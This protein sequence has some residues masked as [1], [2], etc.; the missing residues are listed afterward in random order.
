MRDIFTGSPLQ[1]NS[2]YQEFTQNNVMVLDSVQWEVQ[3]NE[4]VIVVQYVT[5][6]IKTL[7]TM[8]TQRWEQ[9]TIQ[10]FYSYTQDQSKALCR[11][12]PYIFQPQC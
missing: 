8:G 4:S 11:L 3:T 10:M 2:K 5:V 1:S 6:R 12:E 9:M 7:D